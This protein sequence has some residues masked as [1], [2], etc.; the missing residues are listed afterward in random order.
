MK[1]YLKIY[2][3][4]V[5]QNFK[6]LVLSKQN[7]VLGIITFLSLQI[8]NLITIDI[9]FKN[10]GDIGGYS[11][12]QILFIY[13]IFLLP[14]GIDHMISD[15]L[16]LFA[17]GGVKR[18]IYDKYMTKPLPTLF[19]VIIE[20]FDFNALAE[21][22]LAVFLMA[23]YG[24]KYFSDF[25]NLLLF[26]FF[27]INGVLIYL[28]IKIVCAAVAFYTKSSFYL[29]VSV[30]QT[31]NFSKYPVSIYPKSIVYIMYFILP[32]GLTTYFPFLAITGNLNINFM[33]I[34]AFFSGVFFLSI[35]TVFWNIAE[36]NYESTGS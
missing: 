14:R 2:K 7:V 18:G 9:I 13:G 23:K 26:L 22:I 10:V 27:I 28:A 31:S 30:Y 15:Y 29:L 17:G 34:L 16:W 24:A 32:F 20:K 4:F 5:I 33:N 12:N 6:I 3:T 35:A 21:L 19:Q 36:K 1:Y 11:K 8:F 25:K